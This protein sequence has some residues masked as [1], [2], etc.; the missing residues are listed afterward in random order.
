MDGVRADPRVLD[1]GE[2]RLAQVRIRTVLVVGQLGEEL[3]YLADALATFG[4][5]EPPLRHLGERAVRHRHDSSPSTAGRL[6]ATRGVRPAPSFDAVGSEGA[7][8]PFWAEIGENQASS[9]RLMSSVVMS[10]E[11]YYGRRA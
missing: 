10:E 1:L 7:D 2:E 3:A 11:G 8:Q 5:N 4:S 9:G 6:A